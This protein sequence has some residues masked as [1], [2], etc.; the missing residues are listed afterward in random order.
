MRPGVYK[1]VDWS[2]TTA[3]AASDFTASNL[4]SGLTSSFTVDSGTSALYLTLSSS[5]TTGTTYTLAAAPTTLNIL[6]GG[7]CRAR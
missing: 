5:G 4:A 7:S 6:R 3:F 2:G 1:L